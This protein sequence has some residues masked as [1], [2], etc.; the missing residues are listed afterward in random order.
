MTYL[1]TG[2]GGFIGS[3]IVRELILRGEAVRVLD[4]FSTGRHENLIQVLD[5]VDLVKGDLRDLDTC[6]G[7][8]QGVDYVLHQGAVSSV[9]RSVDDPFASSDAN[10][11]GT[12]NVLVAARDAGVKRVVYA[13]L[14]SVYGDSPTLPKRE[15]M[16]TRPMS[17]YA[18]SKLA[19]EHYCR[20]FPDVYGLETVSLRYFNVFGPRQDPNSQYSAVIPLFIKAMLSGEPPTIYGDG[21]QS[22]DFT[23]VQNNVEANILAATAPGVS[24]RVFNIACGRRYTL[25]DLVAM[26]NNILWTS[27]EPVFAPLGRRMSS[28]P[29]R[30]SASHRKSWGMRQK[31]TLG[32]GWKRQ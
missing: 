25:L 18:T 28:T 6:R 3:N 11:R 15:D 17:P 21:L 19:G 22:R 10:V 31:L 12:L 9:Q 2:G 4:N 7:A 16:A 26:L 29:L 1:I 32:W 23:Y 20:V 27:I 24:G 13:S 8:V 30:I 14:S 5:D